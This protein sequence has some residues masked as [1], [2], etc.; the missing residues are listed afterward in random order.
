MIK[1]KIYI[2][3]YFILFQIPN[4]LTNIVNSEGNWN[5]NYWIYYQT[6]LLV[7]ILKHKIKI[8]TPKNSKL[9]WNYIFSKFKLFEQHKATLAYKYFWEYRG[10]CPPETE[11]IFD[12]GIG[13]PMKL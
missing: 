11:I 3:E 7:K 12:L 13:T 5:P 2:K 9:V 6:S 10:A 4:T 8:E 1:A